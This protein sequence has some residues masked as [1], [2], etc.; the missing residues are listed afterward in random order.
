MVASVGVSVW[1]GLRTVEDTRLCKVSTSDWDESRA[2]RVA[3]N[4]R[5]G[6]RSELADRAS[7][8]LRARASE[9]TASITTSCSLSAESNRPLMRARLRCAHLHLQAIS[10]A[11]RAAG[12]TSAASDTLL[13]RIATL[14]RPEICA[15]DAELRAHFSDELSSF[16]GE[17]A[18]SSLASLLGTEAID[19]ASEYELEHATTQ[20][21]DAK[22][23]YCTTYVALVAAEGS[24]NRPDGLDEALERAKAAPGP[25]LD[26]AAV[27]A[28]VRHDDF[29]FASEAL[30]RRSDSSSSGPW[31]SAAALLHSRAPERLSD[32]T[33]AALMGLAWLGSP[34]PEATRHDAGQAA[35]TL[36]REAGKRAEAAGLARELV[37]AARHTFGPAHPRALQWEVALAA[38]E[39]D[40]GHH[41][42]ALA[43][44]TRLA[45]PWRDARDAARCDEEK[46]FG[47]RA[48]TKRDLD[49]RRDVAS[50]AEALRIVALAASGRVAESDEGLTTLAESR[51]RCAAPLDTVVRAHE[52]VA[53]ALARVD[54]ERAAKAAA[55][56]V[57]LRLEGGR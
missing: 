28:A 18:L 2:D 36:L 9:W 31:L 30:E 52:G 54:P 25:G 34:I 51:S 49:A 55:R 10:E 47:A 35:A 56:A 32:R 53:R 7:D 1:L 57:T 39:L 46:A 23:V 24:S 27:R 48:W 37:T 38:L 21:R 12:D 33:R 42:E 8:L 13:A 11:A 14:P 40:E 50:E 19:G 4:F 44:A 20:A 41:E 22:C 17:R 3:R 29:T 15:D 16:A 5:E 45:A 43:A 6:G 26:L